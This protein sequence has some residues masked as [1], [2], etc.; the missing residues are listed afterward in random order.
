MPDILQIIVSFFMQGGSISVFVIIYSSRCGIGRGALLISVIEV[1]RRVLC[2]VRLSRRFL[3]LLGGRCILSL[4]R[5]LILSL[6]IIMNLKWRT[7]LKVALQLAGF[8]VFVIG[9]DPLS[10]DDLRSDVRL[11]MMALRGNF[12]GPFN[13]EGFSLISKGPAK[14]MSYGAHL[15]VHKG[16]PE[17]R[18]LTDELGRDV[19]KLGQC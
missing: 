5:L 11:M 19:C 9:L 4:L 14:V 18:L 7:Y 3:W 1:Q 17:N 8:D 6:L 2:A 15:G 10:L 16:V 13:E 12:I